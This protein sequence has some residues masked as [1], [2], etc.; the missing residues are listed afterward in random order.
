MK[1][2]RTTWL[3]LALIVGAGILY[4]RT[5]LDNH[6]LQME[7]NAQIAQAAKES[8]LAVG[9]SQDQVRSVL[10]PPLRASGM[11]TA[12]GTKQSWAYANGV[13][14]DFSEDGKVS[15]IRY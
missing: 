14:I 5:E 15:A 3:V 1:T 11:I 8:R 7:R 4:T 10:G 13:H 6:R 12:R 9:M 2:T